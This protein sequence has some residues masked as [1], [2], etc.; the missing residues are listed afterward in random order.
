MHDEVKNRRFLSLQ[1]LQR[2]DYRHYL[3]Q[4]RLGLGPIREKTIAEIFVNYAA[5]V[6]DYFFATKNPRSEEVVQVPT[7]HLPAEG[8]EP[9][10]VCDKEPTKNVF[11]IPGRLLHDIRFVLL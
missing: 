6:F 3:L 2:G 4:T 5:L 7:L 9:S 10:K 11:D 1:F 8:C